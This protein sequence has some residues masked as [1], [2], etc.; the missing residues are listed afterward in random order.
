MASGHKC[1]WCKG[2][3]SMVVA[4][5]NRKWRMGEPKG[6]SCTKGSGDGESLSTGRVAYE[7]GMGLRVS[8][9]FC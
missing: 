5:M 4:E 6:M 1:L 9:V 2:L 8:A 3:L 7:D